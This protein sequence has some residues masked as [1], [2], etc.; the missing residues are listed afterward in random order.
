MNS[1]LKASNALVATVDYYAGL[2]SELVQGNASK[3]EVIG[4]LTTQLREQ[5]VKIKLLEDQLADTD[6]AE[7]PVDPSTGFTPHD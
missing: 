2:V 7:E 6:G 3:D 5:A 1:S 4:R